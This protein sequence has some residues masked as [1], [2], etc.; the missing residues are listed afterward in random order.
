MIISDELFLESQFVERVWAL[1]TWPLW[2]SNLSNPRRPIILKLSLSCIPWCSLASPHWWQFFSCFGSL[3][4]DLIVLVM[5][6]PNVWAK[7]KFPAVACAYC[8]LFYLINCWSPVLFIILPYLCR[9]VLLFSLV[10]IILNK[11]NL[12]GFMIW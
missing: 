10:F 5:M 1:S 3:L 11:Q 7:N 9:N 4:L 2:T 8:Y 6:L 12:S